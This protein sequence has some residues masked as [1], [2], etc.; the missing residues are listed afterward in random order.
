MK[1][2]REYYKELLKE[3]NDYKIF[4]SNFLKAFFCGG[5]LCMVCEII[6]LYLL[7]MNSEANANFYILIIVIS[8]SAILTSLGIY[9]RIGE[10]ARCGLSIPISGFANS[11]VSAS[12]E[13]K[14]E[15]LL[16]GIGSNSLKLAGAVI[17]TGS[18]SSVI[19]NIIRYIFEVLIWPIR[20]KMFI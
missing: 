18:V 11:C 6:R 7:K 9:D 17:V 1:K 19:V 16:L 20:L 15:G 13:Y 2:S 8:S 5:T 3:K 12:M 4:L 10:F 14:H